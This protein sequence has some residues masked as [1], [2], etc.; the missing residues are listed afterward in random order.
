VEGQGVRRC[1]AEVTLCGDDVSYG[2]DELRS[3]TGSR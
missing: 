1:P 2:H 3:V